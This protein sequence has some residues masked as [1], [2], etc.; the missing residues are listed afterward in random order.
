MIENAT[1][2]TVGG[3]LT[4]LILREVF[5]F[6]VKVRDR[7]L[8]NGSSRGKTRRKTDPLLAVQTNVEA[9][10]IRL[11]RI[12]DRLDDLAEETRS[13]RK[14]SEIT[15]EQAERMMRCVCQLQET[16]D[17]ATRRRTGD[18]NPGL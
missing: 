5:A 2:I 4:L 9:V 8:D 17:E 11:D 6:V 14:Q 10:L 13:S 7:S 12:V 15:G 16:V 18:T 1:E 3:I